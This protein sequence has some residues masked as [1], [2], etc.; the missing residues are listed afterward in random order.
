MVTRNVRRFAVTAALF[1]QLTACDGE[2]I[3]PCPDAGDTR[4]ARVTDMAWRSPNGLHLE[5]ST[6]GRGWRLGDGD[7]ILVFE[8]PGCDR[9]AGQAVVPPIAVGSGGGT[10]HVRVSTELPF[11]ALETQYLTVYAIGPRSRAELRIV[12]RV[13]PAL[14]ISVRLPYGNI[15]TVAFNVQALACNTHVEP[16]RV[17]VYGGWLTDPQP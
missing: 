15:T 11:N 8:S 16:S 6:L 14:T 5:G 2:A 9:P 17:T 4:D 3:A 10:L 12:D 1:V 13:Q 7:E